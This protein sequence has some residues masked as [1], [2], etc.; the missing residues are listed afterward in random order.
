MPWPTDALFYN[1]NEFSILLN[2]KSEYGVYALFDAERR[3]IL[4]DCGTIL[5]D[6]MRLAEGGGR[7]FADAP[8]SFS[9]ILV[10]MEQAV[11]LKQELTAQLTAKKMARGA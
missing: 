2:A 6:L 10:P 11:L 4:I 7:E 9:Y 1:F 5:H 8:V 3:P